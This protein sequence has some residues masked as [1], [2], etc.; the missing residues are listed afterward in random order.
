[1]HPAISSDPINAETK[2][3]YLIVFAGALRGGAGASL[4][5][6]LGFSLKVSN[7]T[8]PRPQAFSLGVENAFGQLANDMSSIPCVN[9]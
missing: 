6:Q 2:M 3:K 7:N 9:P 8:R 4:S 1:V 5:M